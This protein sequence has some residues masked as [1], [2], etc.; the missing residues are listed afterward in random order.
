L[1]NRREYQTLLHHA[2]PAQES[3]AAYLVAQFGLAP[4]NAQARALEVLHALIGA[5]LLIPEDYWPGQPADPF[6]HAIFR[7]DEALLRADI[8]QA[9]ESSG[10]PVFSN[11]PFPNLL[12]DAVEWPAGLELLLTEGGDPNYPNAFGKTP[13]MVAAHMNRI[14]SVRRLLKAGAH[15]DAMTD[16]SSGDCGFPGPKGPRRTAL[17][18]AAENASPVLMK[19]L[20][21]AGADTT[22]VDAYLARNPRLTPAERGAGVVSLVADAERFRGPSFDCTGARTRTEKTICDSEVLR[23]FDAELARAYGQFRLAEGN[24]AAVSQREWLQQRDREC[25]G[26]HDVTDCLAESTRTR[27]RYLHNRIATLQPNNSK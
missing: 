23:I 9:H 10:D 19:L 7:R 26:A 14:D 16:A 22:G 15:V 5:R 18:Y 3:I 25:G 2:G 21:E 27:I 13:L 1:W 11:T 8:E 12:A 17:T 24:A 20:I 6:E 4:E